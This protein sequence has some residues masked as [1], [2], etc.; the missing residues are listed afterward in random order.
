MSTYKDSIQILLNSQF[1][2]KY[3]NGGLLSNMHFSFPSLLV[4]D[5]AIIHKTISI[6]NCQIPVSY[7]IIN[8]YNDTLNYQIG[9]SPITTVKITNGNYNATTFITQFKAQMGTGWDASINKLTGILTFTYTSNFT[10]LANSSLF[11]IMGFSSSN[12]TSTSLTLIAP[13]LADFSGIRN[14]AIRSSTLSLTNRD[15]KTNSYSQNIQVIPVNQPAYGIIKFENVANFT[16]VLNNKH[17][18]GFDIQLIDDKGNF[19]DM[20]NCHWS[21]TLQI[22]ITKRTQSQDVMSYTIAT[23]IQEIINLLNAGFNPQPQQEQ[24]QIEDVAAVDT[25]IQQVA[26]DQELID[27]FN[28]DNSLDVL[29]YNHQL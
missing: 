12:Y 4:D 29:L 25:N 8:E 5:P 16:C 10:F 23:K 24:Q 2:T 20:N 6:S 17:L 3:N 28:P 21:I 11:S 13:N 22:D 14:I 7:Y 19:V 9:N 27:S 1:A 15:C 18:D 26:A